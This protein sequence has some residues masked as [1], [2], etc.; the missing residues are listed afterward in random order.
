ML[1]YKVLC[2]AS[3]DLVFPFEAVKLYMPLLKPIL[4]CIYRH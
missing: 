3:P 1:L 2:H 4:H